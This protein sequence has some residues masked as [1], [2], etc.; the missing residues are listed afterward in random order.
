MKFR[1]KPVEVEAIQLTKKSFDAVLDF[2]KKTEE[3]EDYRLVESI[4]CACRIDIFEGETVW[5]DNYVVREVSGK[6][7]V[8]KEFLFNEL[9][10]RTNDEI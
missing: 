9:H 1:K 3:V 10:E 6:L 2:I 4:D 5:K 7:S 8:F